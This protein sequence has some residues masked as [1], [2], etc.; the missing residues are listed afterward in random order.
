MKTE[1]TKEQSEKLLS[2]G[3]DPETPSYGYD[4]ITFGIGDLIALLPRFIKRKRI[5]KGFILESKYDLT[6]QN[7]NKKWMVAYIDGGANVAAV[8]FGEY[9]LIDGL[10]NLVLWCVEHGYIKTNV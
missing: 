3:L 9:H 7:Y 4:Y 8:I 6:I 10:Y 5:D 1:L 2:L